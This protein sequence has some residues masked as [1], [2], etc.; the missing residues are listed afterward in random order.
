MSECTFEEAMLGT[1]G[2]VLFASGSPFPPL[3][4]RDRTYHPAQC[5]NAYVFPAIGH[6]AILSKASYIPT[7]IFLLAAQHLS[8][9]TSVDE[10]GTGRLFPPFSD[11]IPTSKT[12]MVQLCRYFELSGIGLR[13]CG[14]IWDDLIETATWTPMHSR[15]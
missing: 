1:K 8:K 4:Q 6:A 7:E 2:K 11:I 12:I 9:L 5:N 10:A 13:P 14:Y 3:H 15:L